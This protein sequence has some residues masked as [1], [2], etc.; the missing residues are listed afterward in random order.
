[1]W[2][3]G[4]WRVEGNK[5]GGEWDNGNSIINKIY[6]KIYIGPTHTI[7][8]LSPS[9]FSINLSVRPSYLSSSS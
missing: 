8:L 7:Y 4:G 1:M 5:R 3:G 9:M 6:L 2:V